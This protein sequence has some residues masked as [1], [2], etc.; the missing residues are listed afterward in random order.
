MSGERGRE[1]QV[2]DEASGSSILAHERRREI[3]NNMILAALFVVFSA[4]AAYCSSAGD[5]RIRGTSQE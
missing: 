2:R 3:M 4:T 1:G 5:D